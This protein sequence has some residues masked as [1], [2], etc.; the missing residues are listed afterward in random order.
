LRAFLYRYLRFVALAACVY[1]GLFVFVL[2]TAKIPHDYMSSTH[3]LRD[4]SNAVLGVLAMG[5]FFMFAGALVIALDNALAGLAEATPDYA[6]RFLHRLGGIAAL[7]FGAGGLLSAIVAIVEDVKLHAILGAW[8]FTSFCETARLAGHLQ[9]P[10]KT[11]ILS[12]I[13][14]APL[15]VVYGVLG[16]LWL[17][18]GIRTLR[19]QPEQSP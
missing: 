10:A 14:N 9:C 6:R 15:F 1:A 17:R 2:L 4:A 3:V 5:A 16:L 18:Q 11:P 12:W 7:A 8:H 13:I 19:T